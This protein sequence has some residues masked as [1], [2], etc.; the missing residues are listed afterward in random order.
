MRAVLHVVD[1]LLTLDGQTLISER[2][3]AIEKALKLDACALA[4]PF[5][6]PR[7]LPQPRFHSLAD[8][9]VEQFAVGGKAAIDVEQASHAN[10]KPARRLGRIA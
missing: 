5:G 8:S 4:I 3:A 6:Y 1:G 9:D 10:L 7:V 2:M